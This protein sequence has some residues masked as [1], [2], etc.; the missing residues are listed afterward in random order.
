MRTEK[1][2]R[3]THAPRLALAPAPAP[4]PA[5]TP[6]PAAPGV[7]L[8]DCSKSL[9][10]T[11]ATSVVAGKL[12]KVIVRTGPA[13]RDLSV[14]VTFPAGGLCAGMYTS[15]PDTNGSWK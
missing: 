6:A 8:V 5:P 2:R 12:G 13:P 14:T 7:E 9:S 11:V 15:T 1:R 10:C 3:L 4:A